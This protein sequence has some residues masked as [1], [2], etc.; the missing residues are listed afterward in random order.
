[1][2]SVVQ[3]LRSSNGTLKIILSS[4]CHCLIYFAVFSAQYYNDSHVDAWLHV[5]CK[6]IQSSTG[7]DD[8]HYCK[9]VFIIIENGWLFPAIAALDVQLKLF[10]QKRFQPATPFFTLKFQLI[11]L[12]H[13]FSETEWNG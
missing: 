9:I 13:Y 5:D 4:L 8:R 12:L 1:M 2:S 10:N 7:S 6:Q 11:Y 3:H